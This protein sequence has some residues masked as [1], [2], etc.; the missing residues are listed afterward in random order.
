M[1]VSGPRVGGCLA[2]KLMGGPPHLVGNLGKSSGLS[3]WGA[4][5]EKNKDLDLG[6]QNC[7]SWSTGKHLAWVG[8]AGG[9]Y[10]KGEG[11]DMI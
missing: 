7:N 5:L 3:P 8:K 4:N 6:S 1:Q 10:E 9:F 11:D 2:E